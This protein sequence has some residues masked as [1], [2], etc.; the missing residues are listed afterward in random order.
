[1]MVARVPGLKNTLNQVIQ[2]FA[3]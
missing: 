2:N 3:F 1:M